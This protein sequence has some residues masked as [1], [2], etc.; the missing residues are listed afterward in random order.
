MIFFGIKTN[1]FDTI[2]KFYFLGGKKVKKINKN[3]KQLI[4]NKKNNEI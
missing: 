3:L 4:K 1:K 2:R